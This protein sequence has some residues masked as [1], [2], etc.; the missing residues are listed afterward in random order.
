MQHLCR[1]MAWVLIGMLAA[2]V[3]ADDR[4]IQR[5]KE[6]RRTALVIG[7][8]DYDSAPLRNPVNDARDMAA[9]LEKLGFRVTLE[10]NASRRRMKTAI[11]QLGK[12]LKDG[13]VGL[14]Y[15]AGHGIQVKGRNYL[16][17]V[18]A[19]IMGESDV[20]YEAVDAG[21][22]LGKMADAQNR[23]NIVILDACRNNPFAR[24]FRKPETG[25][26]RMDAPTG[27]L[28]VYATAPGQS[29]ADGEGKRNGVFTG[30]LLTFMTQPGLKV[31]DVLKRTRVAVM[32]ETDNL[33][34]P[35]NSSSLTGDFYFASREFP[36]VRQM[37]IRP[38]IGYN[39]LVIFYQYRSG[40]FND[41]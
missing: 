6:E 15:Y 19:D 29:A 4:G 39:N 14:F 20:E 1:L 38:S 22:V 24:S 7:N 25:L 21:R 37:I 12:Q 23:L 41:I 9:A 28:V 30:H 35:W 3:Q 31:E 36:F 34:V 5:V 10:Q 33:Q 40:N 16:L 18:D 27:S 2:P 17:P 32:K 8:G 26:A 11:N 13:G